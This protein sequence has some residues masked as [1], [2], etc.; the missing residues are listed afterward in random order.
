MVKG[1]ISISNDELDDL[2]IV[3]ADGA[4]TY[5]FCVV[6]DDWDMSITH[7]IRG[8]DHVNNTPRQINI[9]RALG[10]PLPRVRPPADRSWAT[11]G[12]KM[13]QAPRR[14]SASRAYDEA[15][16]LPEA[17]VNYLARLGWSHGDDELFTREQLVQW[18]DGSTTWRKSPAQLDE[19]KLRWV[20]A[21]LP[22][23][24]PTTSGS[25]RWSPQQLARRGIARRRPTL[26][27]R[28]CALFKDRCATT[29]ELADWLAMFFADVQ[30]TP[31]TWRR[32][33]P[34]RCGRRCATL[35]DKL[36]G[37]DW[38]KAA[39]AAAIKET[40][41]AHGLKM[42]QLAH[43]GARAGVRPRA[44][45]VDRCGARAVPARDV[46]SRVCRRA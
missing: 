37:V 41:A 21:Q 34:T 39:I 25:R 8:D 30:P 6:V 12:E 20:N 22:E 35:R 40:L 38:D 27:A 17:M 28:V 4:P 11:T 45:A 36:A 18:F 5:N 31:K 3:R 32:T 10:A 26:L 33:S 16:Y 7:V 14:R 13:T 15:G 43:A 46:C 24:R 23:G 44:D 29:V 19:A 42:P 1:P 2:V 9:F